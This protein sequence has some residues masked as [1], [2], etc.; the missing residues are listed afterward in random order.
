MEKGSAS[1]TTGSYMA[2]GGGGSTGAQAG[3]GG[4]GVSVTDMIDAASRRDLS[5][6][7]VR[8]YTFS[9]A[10]NKLPRPRA[11]PFSITISVDVGSGVD[12]LSDKS[13]ASELEELFQTAAT[14][15]LKP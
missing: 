3:G 15:S 7:E 12:R 5:S 13:R 1:A 4:N 2:A 8:D 9:Y 6:R 11:E 10:G 14:A